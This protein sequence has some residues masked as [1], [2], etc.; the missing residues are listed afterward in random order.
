M[1]FSTLIHSIRN[2]LATKLIL[3]VVILLSAVS[4]LLTTFFITRQKKLLHVEL[5]KR[6]HSL[7]Q[8]LAYNS[9]SHLFSEDNA[10]IQS[11]VSGVKEEPDMEEVLLTDTEGKI[12]AFTDTTYTGTGETFTIPSGVDSTGGEYWFPSGDT[13]RQRVIIPV[14]IDELVVDTD[15]IPYSSSRGNAVLRDK[16]PLDLRFWFPGFTH[17][18][19]EITSTVSVRDANGTSTYIMSTSLEN[20]TLRLL[21]E[22]GNN[23]FW[24]H[25]GRYLVFNCRNTSTLSVVDTETGNINSLTS[26]GVHGVPCF[27]P[28]DRYV[29]TTI[30]TK[31]GDHRLFRIPREGGKPEQLTFHDGRHWYPNCSP[32]GKW[33]VYADYDNL[34]LYV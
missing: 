8:N 25:N 29:I 24:S 28:D 34:V 17:N 27:T 6:A 5:Y 1:F 2:R 22:S 33:I 26:I 23:G 31:D 21:I 32:N 14:K 4:I 30:P 12:L 7:A 19:K 20:R 3:V 18:S 13:Q 11:L 10:T 9:R 16:T 15:F